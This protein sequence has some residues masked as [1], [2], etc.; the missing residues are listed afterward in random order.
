MEDFNILNIIMNAALTTD[1]GESPDF[2]RKWATVRTNI[3]GKDRKVLL[4]L[5][6]LVIPSAD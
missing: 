4:T 1:S 2:V 6:G 5:K 3:K